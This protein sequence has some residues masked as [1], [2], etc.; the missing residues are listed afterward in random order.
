MI[1]NNYSKSEKKNV[2][3]L[4]FE[5][6]SHEIFEYLTREDLAKLKITNKFFFELCECN[7]LFRDS[8]R[9]LDE[10]FMNSL[11]VL[12]T[13]EK[14]NKPQEKKSKFKEKFFFN[15]SLNSFMKGNEVETYNEKR[16]Q[17]ANRK[18]R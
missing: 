6:N 18:K 8:I 17:S 5:T 12:T 3:K 1:T 14:Q 16:L 9:K 10:I 11:N 4:V 15:K 2:L 7:I 13:D